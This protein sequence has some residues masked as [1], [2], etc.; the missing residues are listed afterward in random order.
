MATR[1]VT[2]LDLVQNQ[3]LKGRFESVA[4]DPTTGAFTGWVIYNTTEKT[5]K[6][7]DGAAWQRLVVSIS[8]A[9]A[10]SEAITITNN[11]DG[12]VTITP[13][14]AS[15]TDDGV[16]SASDKA[17]LDA[18]TA[19]DSVGTLV[20]R[21]ANG[22]FQVA[23]PVN[24]LDAAN[25]SYVDSARTGLDV[26]ASVKVAT[27]A[28]INLSTDL[29]PGEEIDGYELVAGDRILVK[30]QGTATENGIY[31]IQSDGSIV[32][33]ADADS[34]AEVTPGLFTFVEQGTLNADSGW[35]LITDAPISLGT[36][37]LEFSLFS[38]AGNIL[39]GDGLSKT[40]DVLN[41][42]T[43]GTSIEI[44]ADALRIASGAAGDALSWD[45]GVLDVVVS[46]D[47]GLKITSDELE[48][49][50][51][52]NVA[53]LTT[54]TDGLALK[55]D[56][57]GDG[58][59]FTAGVLSRNVIDLGQGSDDTTGTLPV[60]QGG[61]GATTEANARLNLGYTTT[62]FTTSTPVLA[63]V[64]SQAIGNGIDTA[65]II[66]HNF[67]TRAVVVQ[68]YDSSTYDTV[69]ADVERTSDNTVTVRFSTAPATG[70]FTAVIT[71]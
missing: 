17:K 50:L 47:G 3:I 5:L 11:S 56:V 65:Y 60:D 13:N 37:G 10:A 14:L 7:Y 46:S 57:A 64:S 54:T 18:S 45:A 62:G 69:I 6:Y 53:G 9:G 31:V 19:S 23:T 71:G 30:D 67:G 42:N 61:T 59:T 15:G 25:K 32:R 4:N 58:L 29:F 28:P 48:I 70:A 27:T 16:M 24:G 41:V 22:R 2:N 36:T 34:N 55:S 35:V 44:N 8:S 33:A 52:G 38:V 39:A 40:G 26:K 12:T 49:K 63:R 1:F 66:T 43:D 51:D 20:I 68:V 21:D